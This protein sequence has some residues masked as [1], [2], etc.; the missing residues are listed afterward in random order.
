LAAKTK[1]APKSGSLK[2]PSGNKQ[3]IASPGKSALDGS[4][5]KSEGTL[6]PDGRRARFALVL[7]GGG[8]RGAYEAGVI[9]YIRTRLPTEIAHSP[10]FQ[11]FCGTSVGA[12]NS[13]YMASTAHEPAYQGLRI[14]KLW[15]E[16]SSDDIYYAD[17]QALLGFLIKSGFFMGTNFFGLSSLLESKYGRISAFPFK[18]ILDTTPFVNYMRRNI[19]WGC[20]HR[21]I[22]QG[23]VD[24]VTVSTTHISTGKP[25]VFMESHPDVEF[26]KG[27]VDPILCQLSPKHILASAALPI[28]FPLIRINQEYY[29]D[30]S[31]RQNT[32]MSPAIQLGAD[33]IFLIS[34]RKK[35]VAQPHHREKPIIALEPAVGDLAG[36]LLNSIF[37][38]KL[39]Y[40][41]NQLRRINY[42][43]RDLESIYGPD[44][45]E[46]LNALRKKKDVPG[47][48]IHETKKIIPF[49]I[50][51]SERMGAIAAHAL[52]KIV[53]TR[54]KVS[55]LH[56]FFSRVVEGTPDGEN[57]L[58]SYF[59]FEREYLE[60]LLDLGFQDAAK[61]HDNLVKF[62]SGQP[63][64]SE[65]SGTG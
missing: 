57:D 16:L 36:Q 38:D 45:L 15:Q 64:S 21:N 55:P 23:I 22:Q 3:N 52:K 20:M 42:L 6:F 13:A 37:L 8:A 60:T 27:G 19:S 50:Q 29:G 7:S 39:E 17:T 65:E 2:K 30:G 49:V 47:K 54:K 44:L 11:I 58:V 62:F 48:V 18:S 43:I 10:M 53:S 32:P 24:A 12:I 28:F 59:M 46:K 40:D 1:T 26:R 61:E 5:L 33:H 9:H 14:K 34:L 63:L 25:A 31:L 35:T 51:P 56:R 41:L 4:A